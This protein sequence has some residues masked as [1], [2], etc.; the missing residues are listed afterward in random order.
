MD[1]YFT[2]YLWASKVLDLGKSPCGVQDVIDKD[3]KAGEYVE[4]NNGA[5]EALKDFQ[6]SC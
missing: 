3:R 4:F 6:N 1:D 5:Q 2:G